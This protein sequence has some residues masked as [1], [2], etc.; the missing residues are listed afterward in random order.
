MDAA[1]NKIPVKVVKSKQKDFWDLTLTPLVEGNCNV[2][3]TVGNKPVKNAPLV[4]DVLPAAFAKITK[5]PDATA[6]KPIKILMETGHGLTPKDLKVEIKDTSGKPAQT[7]G[8]PT[9]KQSADNPD[10]FELDLV[11][12]KEGIYS[13]HVKYVDDGKDCEN[14]PAKLQVSYKPSILGFGP[15]GHGKGIQYYL[16]DAT[17]GKPTTVLIDTVNL[18]P[19]DIVAAVTQTDGTPLSGVT[20]KK[21]DDPSNNTEGH[22][23][24]AITFVP[25]M[26]GPHVFN[27]VAD[28]E[29]VRETPAKF[30][31]APKPCVSGF[32]GHGLD[33]YLKNATVGKP[34]VVPVDVVN[35]R[36]EDL[37]CKVT[38]KDTGKEVPVKLQDKGNNKF[39]LVFVPETPGAHKFDLLADGEHAPECPK[40][41][42]VKPK[43][44]VLGFGTED[45]PHDLEYYLKNATVGKPTVVPMRVTNLRPEDIE[46]TIRSNQTGN[47][48]PG[49]TVVDK[50][51]NLFEIT[52]VPQ[53][54]GPH[55]FHLI[56]DKEVVPGTPKDFKVLPKP[57]IA[58]FGANEG[59]PK[60]IDYY[61][62]N[63][64][65]GK[66]T[67][68]PMTVVNLKPED[69]KCTVNDQ[70]TGTQIPVKIEDKGNN[71]FELT[72]VPEVEGPHKINIIADNEQV[73]TLPKIFKVAPKPTATLVGDPNKI[74][75]AT[76]PFDF[77]LDTINLK[78]EDVQVQ[79]FDELGLPMKLP[80]SIKEN[81]DKTFT[82]GFTPQ[83]PGKILAK[84]IAD[85]EPIK[86]GPVNITVQPAPYAKLVGPP[87]RMATASKPFSIEIETVNVPLDELKYVVKD[88]AGQPIPVTVSEKP[89]Q[90]NNPFSKIYSIDFVPPKQGQL[91]GTVVFEGKPVDGTP[92]IITVAHKPTAKFQGGVPTKPAIATKPYT[93]KLDTVNMRP[94]D[95]KPEITDELGMVLPVTVTQSPDGSMDLTFV[96]QTPGKLNCKI[97]ADGVPIEGT[98]FQLD[99]LPKPSAKLHGTPNLNAVATK[100]YELLLD[101]INLKPED[102]KVEVT[103]DLGQK[104]GPVKVTPNP[105]GTFSVMFVPMEPG[106]VTARLV[107][108]GTPVEGTPL[109]INVAPKP[110]AKFRGT[111]LPKATA[112]KPYAIKLDVINLKPEDVFVKAVDEYGVP[113]AG[114]FQVKDNKDGTFDVCFTPDKPGKMRIAA[115]AD[116]VPIEGCPLILEV[117]PKPTAR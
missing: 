69:I 113:F 85:G 42:D 91:T 28:G 61:L 115:A 111:N 94:E 19:E 49:I 79:L 54:A 53:E 106:V 93:I 86:G 78:P 44:A 92:V 32:G 4:L 21:V 90:D 110:S 56:A 103:D 34:T 101:T 15:H 100:P 23:L 18:K 117:D 99:V 87:N 2:K 67:V 108:D 63:A 76:R 11:M 73:P 27:L 26:P 81:P 41:F 104:V 72:F 30:N 46:C 88:E 40:D 98:P 9:I 96:P 55:K 68:I 35:L 102:L 82:V 71:K 31:V 107:A 70:A 1:G 43:P 8:T 36:P 29:Q 5:V 22:E 50:G 7:T 116:G 66:P 24:M 47:K 97:A 114:P 60:D 77:K 109:K 12:P 52:F 62:R 74:A 83:V 112:E 51:N 84:V 95:I 25:Q 37:K 48:I 3:V 10:Q 33:Y 65:V 39:E 57:A 58:H 13:V 6:T 64:T 75:K 80:V 14:S 38:S 89:G 17:V 16:K 59:D 105:D 45:D 20:V